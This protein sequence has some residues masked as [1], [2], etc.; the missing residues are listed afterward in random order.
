MIRDEAL[1]SQPPAAADGRTRPKGGV[2]WDPPLSADEERELAERIKG[3]DQAARRQLILANLRAVIEIARRFRSGKVPLDDLIQEGNLGLIRASADFDPSVHDCRFYTYAEIW[4]KAFIH[5]ALVR[6]DSLIR[7]PQHVFLR[8]RQERRIRRA[9]VSSPV[10]DD[11]TA[12]DSAT[13]AVGSSRGVGGTPRRPDRNGPP[14]PPNAAGDVIPEDGE[15]VPLTDAI[16]D[17]QRPDQQVVEQEQRILLEI[18]LRR[19]SPVE[20]WVIRERYGLCLQI[21][22]ERDWSRSGRRAARRDDPTREADADGQRRAH[23][24]R[25]YYELERACGLSRRRILQVEETALE[26]LRDALYPCLAPAR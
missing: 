24:H 17:D 2:R 3:G 6:S 7:V 4:I 23:F 12:E 22:E 21:P 10:A 1:E 20:A 16:V 11:R 26:K 15:I 18:A 14:G 25:S 9:Q 19:L 5:R 8:R 13:A